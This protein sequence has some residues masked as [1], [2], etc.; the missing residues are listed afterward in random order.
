MK[1][2]SYPNEDEITVKKAWWNFLPFWGCSIASQIQV[3]L[4][5]LIQKQLDE[6]GIIKEEFWSQ[7]SIDIKIKHKIDK[8]LIEYLGWDKNSTFHPED[9][10]HIIMQLKYG[11]LGEVEFMMAVEEDFEIEWPEELTLKID[12]GLKYYQFIQHIETNAKTL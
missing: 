9:E 5:R 4:F 7:Y 6:R 2:L 8:M 11:D 1:T 12:N 10:F 3:E